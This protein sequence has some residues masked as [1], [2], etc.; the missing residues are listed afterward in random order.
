LQSSRRLGGPS[1]ARE[2]IARDGF[3]RRNQR[4]AA[5]EHQAQTLE[6]E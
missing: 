1:D 5:L 6:G 2:P 4:V 3:A